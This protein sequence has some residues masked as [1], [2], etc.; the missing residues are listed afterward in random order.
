MRKILTSI[1]I[2]FSGVLY[3]Q[4]YYPYQG[5]TFNK[6]HLNDN[7]W[8]PKIEINRTETISWSFHQSKITGRIKNFEQAAARSGKLCGVY[9]FDDSDVYKI[10][11]GA[12]YSLQIKYD[13]KL[14]DY[15]DSLIAVIGA[16]QEPDGYLFTT[17]TMGDTH[18][19]IGSQRYEKEHELS[20]ELY[21]MGHFYE[22]AT[23]HF[24]ATGKRN[25]LDLAIK[26]ANHLLTVFGPG[27]KSVAPGHQVIEIGLVK[28]Y[29]ATGDK[30]Y[31]DLSQFFIECRGKR[32]YAK[33]A[34]DKEATVWETGEYWQD[35]KP[36]IEQ[37]EAIG[38][39]V[40]ATYLY[41]GMAD[42]A[43]LTQNQAYLNAIIK[44][45]ENAAGKKT[46][47][48]GGIGS[49]G[50][51]EGFGP[52]YQLPNE[53]AYCETCAGIGNVYWNHRMF[54][55]TGESKY[56][57][58]VERTL[59]NGILGGIGLDG[60]TFYYANPMEYTTINGKLS[61][62]NKR[63]PWF[64][65][66]CC[67]SN[68]CR[69]MPSIPGY[70]YAQKGAQVF[71]NLYIGSESSF[72]I[73]T[74]NSVSVKQTSN[75]PWEGNVK[76]EVGTNNK[77][78]TT[79]SLN[80]RVPGWIDGRIFPT[81]LYE[82]REISEYGG[83]VKV[84]GIEV[85]VRRNNQG[86]FEIN[87]LWKKGDIVELNLPMYTQKVYSNEKIETNKNLISIQR[88]PLMYC[89]EFADND[90]KTSNIVFGTASNFTHN[91]EP[92]LLNGVI[93]LSTTAKVFNF[94][95]QEINTST[96]TVKLI[97]Y[98]ARSNRGIGEMKLWFPTKITGVR[99]EN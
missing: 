10:I 79:F 26:N 27:K 77:K 84:N 85:D 91:F 40:R 81:N 49:S 14:D 64:K 57:D 22:S 18:E 90:G 33:T 15:V 98:Y 53:S 39:A 36:A 16:A 87:R 32:I 75:M 55:L 71:V 86:Y 9:V 4:S 99:I 61:G 51:W 37:T 68:I 62:E 1:L 38:H 23:A 56:M 19:W 46:Y 67:P 12:S 24:L 25:M 58:M 42:V 74:K 83:I 31:L 3:A 5:I 97:P 72:S 20:H 17:R 43:A 52:D 48:T 45:W 92:N 41:S 78:G 30:R 94:T 54:M 28:M 95:E 89:A 47:I 88:G 2:L 59:Y 63:S 7:F 76:F 34:G 73:D 96:K 69:F 13:K 70:I 60:K 11:E 50:G 93:T 82:V 80:L 35:H 21:N 44:I 6:V 65:C 29:L 8:L 66:S